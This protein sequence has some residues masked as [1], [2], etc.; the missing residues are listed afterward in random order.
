MDNPETQTMLG[1]TVPD[2]PSGAPGFP[3]GFYW[4]S[5]CPIFNFLCSVL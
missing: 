5:C 3:L 1:A 2:H 4:G